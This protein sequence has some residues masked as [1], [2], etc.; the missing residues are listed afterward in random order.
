M[1]VYHD[2]ALDNEEYAEHESYRYTCPPCVV[3]TYRGNDILDSA[4]REHAEQCTYD[5]SDTARQH[6]S[7]DNG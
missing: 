5:I 6:R 4:E 7:A 2:N 3:K 1:L